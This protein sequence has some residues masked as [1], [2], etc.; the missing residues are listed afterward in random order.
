MGIKR[1]KGRMGAGGIEEGKKVRKKQ[2]GKKGRGEERKEGER[3]CM[4]VRIHYSPLISVSFIV[5]KHDKTTSFRTFPS[6]LR[7]LNDGREARYF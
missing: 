3:V 2:G 1:K 4:S 6:C 7:T 5:E